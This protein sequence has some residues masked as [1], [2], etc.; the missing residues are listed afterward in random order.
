MLGVDVGGVLI[1]SIEA[2]GFET[3]TA[4]AAWRALSC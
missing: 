3:S 1:D 2:D 4:T